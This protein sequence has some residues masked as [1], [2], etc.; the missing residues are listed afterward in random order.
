MFLLFK[1]PFR[2]FH[3][4]NNCFGE[5]LA[6]QFAAQLAGHLSGGEN[7]LDVF[8]YHNL[9]VKAIDNLPILR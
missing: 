9:H 1:L 2:L 3:L 6:A 5:V 4:F 8:H 7:L